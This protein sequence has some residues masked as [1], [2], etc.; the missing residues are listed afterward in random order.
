MSH[1]TKVETTLQMQP[2]VSKAKVD[3]LLCLDTSGSMAGAKLQAALKGGLDMFNTLEPGNRF[4]LVTFNDAPKV[5]G[6]AVL[7][8]CLLPKCSSMTFF[9]YFGSCIILGC[10][11]HGTQAEN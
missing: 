6:L 10:A 1:T 4:G 5:K 11:S 2:S 7:A 8:F 3:L 9:L